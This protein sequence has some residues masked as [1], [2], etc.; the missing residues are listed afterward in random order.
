MQA[1]YQIA[2]GF[3]EQCRQKD[4]VTLALPKLRPIHLLVALAFLAFGAVLIAQIEGERG[5]QP[6]ASSG[7]FE[8]TDVKVDIYGP[9]ANTARQSGWKLAQRLAWKE[10]WKRTN[11]GDGP[12]FSDTV[13][14]GLVSGIE[15]QQEQIGPNRYIATLAVLFDRARAGQAL[16]VSAQVMRSPPLLVI[17]VLSDGGISTVFE[18]TTE[19]QKAWAIFRTGESAIDYVRPTGDGPDALLLNA[20]QIN[21]HGRSWWRVLLDQYGAADVVMPLA[22]LERSWPGGPITGHFAARYGPD[23]RLI[24]TFDLRAT[25]PDQLPEMMK[26]AVVKMD[27]LY[28]Q[29]LNIGLLRPDPSL[30]IEAPINA[31]ELTNVSELESVMRALPTEGGAIAPTAGSITLQF[32]TPTADSVSATERA[33]RGVPGV[34]SAATTSLALGGTSVM[35]VSFDGSADQLRAAL[36]SRGLSVTGSGSTLRVVRRGGGGPAQ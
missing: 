25:G 6:I 12:K 24:G 17:P 3:P 23:N 2:L 22:R 34:K 30:I 33:V 14:D 9:D 31:V 10:L 20:N 4:A 16:G 19:W 36:E 26:Q 29:A 35:Q 11:G 13:L 8:V 28:T 1:P 15:V 7:D 18:T 5:A 21:R 27:Q 32:D